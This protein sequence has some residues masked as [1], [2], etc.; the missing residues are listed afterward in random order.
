MNR[1]DIALA[2]VSG[3][4]VGSGAGTGSSTLHRTREGRNRLHFIHPKL[5]F[6]PFLTLVWA[7]GLAEFLAI[8]VALGQLLGISGL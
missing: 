1:K 2:G 4:D 3:E 7:M 6:L 8:C 5:P